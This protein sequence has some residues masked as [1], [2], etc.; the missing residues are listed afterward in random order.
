MR[1]SWGTTVA[2]GALAL[3]MPL[4]SATSADAVACPLTPACP[5]WPGN[6]QASLGARVAPETL[7]K[8]DYAP[9][10]WTVLGKF[11]TADGGHPPALR[12]VL[13]DIDKDVKVS[14]K[15][16]PVC[17]AGR[18]QL[19]NRDPA[20]AVKVCGDSV[21]GKGLAHFEIAFPGE[22]PLLVQ[23]PLTIFNGGEAGGEIT[24]YLHAFIAVPVPTAA[25]T[26]VT[27][28]RKGSGIR[29][30]AKVPV[31]AGGSGSVL[32]FRFKLGKTFSHR[33]RQVGPFEAKCPDDIFKV[34]VAKLLFKNEA[35]TPGEAS[36]TQLKGSLAV[37]CTPR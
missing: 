2:L 32:D 5:P 10:T 35:Q 6:V 3:W 15:G 1:R 11:G 24:L 17:K 23:G 8:R 12:E 27:I 30:V 19:D 22:E 31:V 33:G 26:V 25:V 16:Y 36:S 7:P 34:S 28:A 20:A 4:T 37:P 9:V 18:R 13:F 29:S 21:L 14:A